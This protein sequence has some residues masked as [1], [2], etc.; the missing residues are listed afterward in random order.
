MKQE[1]ALKE[2]KR[3]KIPEYESMSYRELISA[4]SKIRKAAK[5]SEA[6]ADW[7]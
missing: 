4:L 2:A 5:E 7:L 1:E 6:K 3:L